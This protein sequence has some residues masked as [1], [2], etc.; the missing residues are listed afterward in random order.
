MKIHPLTAIVFALLLFFMV[1]SFDH[2]LYILSILIFLTVCSLI[3][4]KKALW[5]KIIRY[6]L[7][8]ALFI[9]LINPLLSKSGKTLLY[10]SPYLPLLGKIKIT[11][12][13]LAFG[14]NMGLKFICIVFIFF[15]YSMM[16]DRDDTFVFFSKHAHKITLM[17]SMTNN[18]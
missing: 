17:L 14:I 5:K 15:L 18:I 12:E 9:I 1:L 16:T 6:S 3:F 10:K 8:N 11:T 7:Y 2:P 4:D 13:A